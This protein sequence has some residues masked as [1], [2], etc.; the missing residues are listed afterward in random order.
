[1]SSG[2]YDKCMRAI[3][4]LVKVVASCPR[5]KQEWDNAASNKNCN[6][7]ATNALCKT[8]NKPYFYHCV[9]NGFRNATLEVCKPRKVIFGN[10]NFL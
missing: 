4:D 8:S 7:I 1:M 10:L 6:Q 2:D 9:I 3:R 5:S